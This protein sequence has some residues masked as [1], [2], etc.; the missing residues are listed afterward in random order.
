MNYYENFLP[1]N[2]SRIIFSNY[3]FIARIVTRFSF[4]P[5]TTNCVYAFFTAALKVSCANSWLREVLFFLRGNNRAS[6]GSRM[7]RRRRRD[8]RGES[9][10]PCKVSPGDNF[11]LSFRPPLRPF[12][13]RSTP[14]SIFC[15]FYQARF[16]PPS[17]ANVFRQR[18]VA[19]E[20][21]W[22]LCFWPYFGRG[23]EYL[24]MS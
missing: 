14:P 5:R 8:A 11:F 24:R 16:A 4:P 1:F 10:V 21:L 17:R 6:S 3:I 13:C 15:N 22:I 7:K 9:N 18:P 20:R 23:R 19:L 2:S 12:I